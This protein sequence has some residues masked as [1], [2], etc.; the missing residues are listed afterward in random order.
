MGGTRF[1]SEDGLRSEMGTCWV[2]RQA[3]QVDKRHVLGMGW[4]RSITVGRHP[5]AIYCR[6]GSG[7]CVC[8]A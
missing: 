4:Q 2:E 7:R 6:R 3:I 5:W 1:G 8:S